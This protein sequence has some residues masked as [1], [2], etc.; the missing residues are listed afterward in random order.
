METEY[1][2]QYEVG[3]RVFYVDVTQP[4]LLDDV[5]VESAYEAHE[6]GEYEDLGVAEFLEAH[7]TFMDWAKD[8]IFNQA[9]A[10]YERYYGGS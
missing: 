5:R 3:E 9:E 4:E 1:E 7:P 2:L 8:E 6:N 10:A